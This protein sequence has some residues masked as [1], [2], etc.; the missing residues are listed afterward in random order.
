MFGYNFEFMRLYETIAMHHIPSAKCRMAMQ[1]T[2]P[3]NGG[4]AIVEWLE[5]LSYDADSHLKAVS[6][7]PCFAIQ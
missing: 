7:N 3:I 6:L 5:W 2:S 4:G 1:F